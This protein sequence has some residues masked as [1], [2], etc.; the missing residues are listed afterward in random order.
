MSG[1]ESN[2]SKGSLNED[3]GHILARIDFS[4][5]GSSIDPDDRTYQPNPEYEWIVEACLAGDPPIDSQELAQA[6]IGAISAELDDFTIHARN[7]DSGEWTYILPD[8]DS[9][10]VDHLKFAF[11]F[12]EPMP[13]ESRP[14]TKRQY[15]ARLDQMEQI[16]GQFGKPTLT[17]SMPVEKAAKR[18]KA[19]AQI[20]TSLDLV[21]VLS[22]RAPAEQHYAVRDIEPVMSSLGLERDDLDCF[23]WENPTPIGHD[24]LFTV[25]TNTEAGFFPAEEGTGERQE[26]EDLVFILSIPRCLKPTEVFEA[27][28]Q[29]AQHCQS[30]LGGMLVDEDGNPPDLDELR[31]SVREVVDQLRS[32]GFE[33][34]LRDTLRLF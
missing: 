26:V 29:V 15:Q 34:G 11:D 2:G 3:P 28:I 14:P 12:V 27:M 19:L 5:L 1:H 6:F 23:V 31:Q 32:H 20:Q 25:E 16:L 7:L 21:A 4:D 9:Q 30:R 13:A 8:E 18:S 17:P 22:L 33:P 24:F 10:T